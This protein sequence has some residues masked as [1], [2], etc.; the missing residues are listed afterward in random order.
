MRTV[1][2]FSFQIH[3][4]RQFHVNWHVKISLRK[5]RLRVQIQYVCD[6]EKKIV[7]LSDSLTAHMFP[8]NSPCMFAYSNEH[9][10]ILSTYLFFHLDSL[11]A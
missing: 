8:N 7:Y 10:L 11:C 6:D 2:S 9:T 1:L 3:T 5:I 4:C